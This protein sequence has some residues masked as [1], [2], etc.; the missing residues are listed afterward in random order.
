M[1][2]CAESILSLFRSFFVVFRSVWQFFFGVEMA[3]IKKT[4]V[5]MDF[6]LN[7]SIQ[8]YSDATVTAP[9][10][11]FKDNVAKNERIHIKLKAKTKNK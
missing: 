4:A 1:A 7:K 5:Y 10:K 3:D 2:F 9:K 8:I 6:L 11:A